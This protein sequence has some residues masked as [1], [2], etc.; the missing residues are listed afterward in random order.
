MVQKYTYLTAYLDDP[1]K[2][3]SLSEFETLFKLPHQR[4]KRH[5][6]PLVDDKVLIIDKRERF[7]FYK[8]NLKNP[9]L[10][11]YISIAE[12]ERLFEFLEKPLFRRLHHALA[13]VD[14]ALLFGSAATGRYSDIDILSTADISRQISLFEKTYS[15]KLHF[16][17]AKSLSNAFI[18]E[19]R[20]KHIIF[21]N[22]DYFTKILY[23][24]FMEQEAGNEAGE[25]KRKPL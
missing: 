10:L 11:D 9:L 4:V 21:I 13:G 25:A 20:K 15:V 19:L 3:I 5:L 7:L 23:N 8:L 16:V 17:R 12:K 2:I 24:D 1:L 14:D 6:E 22:H 18:E